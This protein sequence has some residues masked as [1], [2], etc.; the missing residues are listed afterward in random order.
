MNEYASLETETSP[1]KDFGR[2]L[3][4]EIIKIIV[5]ARRIFPIQ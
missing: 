1:R 3:R 5:S 2:I 4:T